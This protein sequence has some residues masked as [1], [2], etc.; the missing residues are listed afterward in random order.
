MSF[1]AV[2]KQE[3]SS[4]PAGTLVDGKVIHELECCTIVQEQGESTT[5]L[6]SVSPWQAPAKSIMTITPKEGV[7]IKDYVVNT[8]NTTLG[9]YI[10]KSELTN[11][12]KTATSN[13]V[14]TFSVTNG[15][16]PVVMKFVSTTIKFCELTINYTQEGG[17]TTEPEPT[18]EPEPQP[19]TET[20]YFVNA[21]N[22]TKVNVYA[23]DPVQN[24]NWPGVAA[25]KEAEQI[26]GYDVYSYTVEIGKYKNVIFN[27][28]SGS[29]TADLVWTAGKYYVKNGWYTKE[30]A[31][32][33][34]AKPVEYESVYFV[35][36]Q[37]WGKANIY[38]W[39][40][41]VGTWPGIP[42]TKEAEQLAGY[43]VYSYTAEKGT[44]FG[45][46]I[47]NNGSKQTA[48]L[49]WTA[50]KYYVK[51]AWYTKEE[52]EAK[53]AGPVT[54]PV[55]TYVLMGVKGDWTTGIAMTQNADNANEYVLLQQEILD[56]DAVKVVTLTDG[57]ATAWCGNVDEYSVERTYD[58]MGNIVLAPGKYDFYYK[59]TEDLI[60]IGGEAYPTEPEEPEE[61]EVPVVSLPGRAWAYNLALAVKGTQYTFS[62]Q[63][64]TDANA[65]L[66]FT[67]EAGEEID[68]IDLSAVKAGKNKVALD[69]SELP[70]GQLVSWG[71][72]MSGETIAEMVEVTDASRGIY[73][74]YLPQDVAVDNNP[75]SATFGQ[76]YVIGM[77]GAADGGSDRADQQKR[78]VFVYNQYLDELN[79]TN[80]GYL[81]ANAVELMT[82]KSRQAVHRMAVNPVTNH[83]AFAY[84]VAGASA[85]WSMD[86]ANMAGDAVNLIEGFAITKANALCFDAEGDLYVMD[87]ANTATG[88]AI[89]KV[90]NG[91][92][93]TIAQDGIWG[94]Q[95]ISLVSDGRG[96]L[97][98]AQNRWAVDAYAVLS[99]VNAEGVVDFK[100]TDG[101]P[102]EVKALFPNDANASYRGQCA[103]NVAEDILAF[104][105]NKVV[106]LFQVSYDE[107]TG[108]PSI[109]KIRSTPALGG[110]IDGIA[111]DHAGDLY[112]VSASS[113]RFYKF[114]VP[115]ENNVCTTPADA[116]YAFQIPAIEMVGT[117][118]RA[119]QLDNA[120]IVLTH[121]ADG[122][123]HIYKVVNGVAKAEL[124]QNGVIARDPENAGDLLA[125][126]DI[127]VT[128]DGKLVAV[129][130]MVCQAAEDYVDAG[131]KRGET[132]FYIWNELNA[133]PTVWFKSNMYGN[134]FRSKEGG[135]MALKGT[136]T[137]AQI[138][139]TSI[140]ATKYWS[141]FSV[142]TVIDGVYN[143]PA[144]AADGN[145]HYT[146]CE[147][148]AAGDLD[149]NVL[150]VQYE[151][152]ASATTGNWIV[153]AELANP[154]EFVQPAAIK[155]VIATLTPLTEDLGKKYQGT[156]IVT[157]DDQVLM[158]APFANPDG[159]LVGAEILNVTNGFAAP[160]YVNMVYV[161]EA[162]AATAAATAVKVI[163]GG[164]YITLVADATIHTWN[165]ELNNS[166]YEVYEEE[167]TNLSI[168]LDNLILYGGPSDALQ[169]EVVLGLGE[170]DLTTGEYQLKPESMVSILG[171]DAIFVEGYAYEIDA[172]APSAKAV[173]RCIWNEMPIEL[174]LNMTA[175]PLEATVVVVENAKVEIEKFIIFGDMYDYSLKMTGVWTNEGVDYP[176]LVEVPVYY[177]EATEPSTIFSTVTVGGWGDND[178]WLGFGEGD[179][180]VTT[181]GNTVT[182][183]GIVQNP[184]AGIAIDITISGSIT[185]TGLENAT[186]TVKS[187][188]KIQNGQLIIEKDGVE[189]DAQGAIV[190]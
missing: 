78:G 151:L 48:D 164:L 1:A 180:T 115:T 110:N 24:A 92:L 111:F 52:A 125:I 89:V 72:K 133:D 126:S 43:D 139:V 108:V 29:Q 61:P 38:T 128:E 70:A 154:I 83:V 121:E 40:P 166:D 155:E 160:Q 99:H 16:E 9:T 69:A 174:H 85:I 58:D 102:E 175:A 172:F 179:L 60:Y 67:N 62:F 44:S 21:S 15:T 7:S 20:V 143:E 76:I 156:S 181:V 161:E 26:A 22:W 117:V 71:I 138:M 54:P 190:K 2:E 45:G 173:V 55:I 81:P 159:Q 165:V 184:M 79:P 39:T 129:N 106:T 163:E 150:G 141:R 130:S 158:V 31:E 41:E 147:G 42:M 148:P 107:T 17:T 51:D 94:V 18:P 86:P 188:K 137:N 176:V 153:D 118:K 14:V 74:Y 64:S 28:G 91:V 167:I 135:S 96:G 34:L 68:A 88:G 27:N 95:D 46:V 124:S 134:W 152:N 132:R 178:P 66:V 142:Y 53:L 182:A 57:V 144:G 93:D 189:Y 186:V 114:A 11:A 32:A 185:P 136:S 109:A 171:Q 73:D 104:G 116:K 140:H 105:G 37:G 30:E 56:G 90:A 50:G 13:G 127:A 120:A 19:T 131:Y 3:F 36:N 23:W 145:E 8:K 157:I 75:F 123:A 101:S 98:L 100:V 10:G 6:K 162:I 122:T 169:V 87:N 103:Y 113:E 183:T 5:A 187:V 12:T 80:V 82:D 170:S 177:P 119:V 146:W 97:W 33:Q 77:D 25:T 47:F 149:E 168:D 59:V 35:D 4:C 65:T 112:V 49:K 84:N 63:T